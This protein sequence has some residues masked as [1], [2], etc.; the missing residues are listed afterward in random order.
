M[1]SDRAAGVGMREK[2]RMFTFK[3]FK[4]LKGFLPKQTT[5]CIL[6]HH[7]PPTKISQHKKKSFKTIAL[8]IKRHIHS[9]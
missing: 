4:K 8:F 7:H 3:K 2:M 6:R 5:K 1:V 9:Q